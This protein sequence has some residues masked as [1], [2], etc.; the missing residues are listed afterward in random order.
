MEVNIRPF[1]KF[2]LKNMSKIFELGV[3]TAAHECYAEEVIKN[4]DPEG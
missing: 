2:L 3:F 4:L 1:T